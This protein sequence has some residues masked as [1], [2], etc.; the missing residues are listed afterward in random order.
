MSINGTWYLSVPNNTGSN[1][2][3]TIHAVEATNGLLLSDVPLRVGVSVNPASGTGPTLT[4]SSVT[5]E[6][7][8]IDTSPNLVN[9]TML[10]TVGSRRGPYELHRPDAH[11]RYPRALLPHRANP[12][13]VMKLPS[14]S[15]LLPKGGF[16]CTKVSR[17]S[18]VD[19]VLCWRAF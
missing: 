17:E 6:M 8:E 2:T 5:G 1:V 9:W 13:A 14:G 12:I 15:V 10:T 16:C 3:F 19:W 11:H 18:S 4:W 7:Y